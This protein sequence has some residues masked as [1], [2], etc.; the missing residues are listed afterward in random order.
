[1][2]LPFKQPVIIPQGKGL[3][4]FEGFVIPEEVGEGNEREYLLELAQQFL[5]NDFIPI[6]LVGKRPIVSEWQKI[7]PKTSMRILEKTTGFDNLGLLTGE[8]GGITVIDIDNSDKEKGSD[9]F[10][11]ILREARLRYPDT[12]TVATGGGGTHLYFNYVGNGLL[13]APL[14]EGKTRFHIDIKNNGGQI[15][16]PGSIHPTTG[17]EY[18]V[19]NDSAPIDMS[20]RLSQVL[21]KYQ[22]LK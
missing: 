20:D 7:T 17:K 18:L 22:D 8:S 9:Y 21:R 10:E 3:L 1:M 11:R 5:D 19:T 14:R 12:Y 6:P 4:E 2:E 16:A 13:S 15:V